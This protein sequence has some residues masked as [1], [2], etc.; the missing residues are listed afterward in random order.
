MV[1]AY[2]LLLIDYYTTGT[3]DD[4]FGGKTITK[5]DGSGAIIQIEKDWPDG[6]KT[7]VDIDKTTDNAVVTETPNGQPSLTPV[8]SGTW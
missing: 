8:T 2:Q 6:D 7:V 3:T 4:P 1:K 5:T